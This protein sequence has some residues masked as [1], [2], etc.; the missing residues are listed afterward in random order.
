MAA[1]L[2]FPRAAVN[3]GNQVFSEGSNPRACFSQFLLARSF[4]YFVADL[5]LSFA[6]NCSTAALNLAM[7]ASISALI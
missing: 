7:S 2:I 1:G 5:L 3:P 4:A 6:P